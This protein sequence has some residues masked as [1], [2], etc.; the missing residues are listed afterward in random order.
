[1]RLLALLGV[2]L[3]LVDGA[4]GAASKFGFYDEKRHVRVTQPLCLH[5]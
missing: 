1:M 4:F 5:R 2:T 3:S